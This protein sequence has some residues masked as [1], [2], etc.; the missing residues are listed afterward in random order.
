[1]RAFDERTCGDRE[2]GALQELAALGRLRRDGPA[3]GQEGDEAVGSGAGP[4]PDPWSDAD[5]ERELERIVPAFPLKV[6]IQTSTRCNAA[7]R[8]CPYPAIA[9]GR[10]FQHETMPEALFREIL[11]QLGE[12]AGEVERVSLFLM[13]EPLLDRRL[14][15]WLALARGA[16]PRVTL[17][18]FTNGAPL[19]G[20]LA[21]R[22]ATAG[23]DELCVSVHGFDP[24]VY[25]SVMQGLSFP[26]QMARLREV[27]ALYEAGELGSM[28]VQVVSG[29][30]PELRA[31]L[32]QAEPLVQR[33]TLLKAFSNERVA[34]GVPASPNP[35]EGMPSSPASQKAAPGVLLCQ[36][37]FIKLYILADGRC[38]LCNVD[39]QKS[40]VLGQVGPGPEGQIAAIWGGARYRAL[41][42]GQLRHRFAEGHICARCDY[43]AL[44]EE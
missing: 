44:V 26:R 19:D 7:C 39:W 28:H 14:P 11:R 35:D 36:R 5:L 13:N 24:I 23:L 27:L 12:R 16:L 9:S 18:L 17:G 34:S 41:R 25:E 21:R 10:G 32:A 6:Q 40:E 3:G 29:D 42:L 38:V 43:P 2:R 20:T 30:L 37:P 22:L 8:M 1:M 33:H 31:S 4:A 15:D